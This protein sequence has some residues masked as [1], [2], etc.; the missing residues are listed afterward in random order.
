MNPDLTVYRQ[1]VLRTISSI[2]N[3]D[4]WCSSDVD[5]CLE[6]LEIFYP[7]TESK[8]FEVR[9]AYFYKNGLRQ[10]GMMLQ[11]VL[12]FFLFSFL[13]QSVVGTNLYWLGETNSD[14]HHNMCFGRDHIFSQ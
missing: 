11:V 14:E 3:C 5:W 4:F 7:Q 10:N 2:T 8:H 12:L 1:D 6:Y 9:V 13:H